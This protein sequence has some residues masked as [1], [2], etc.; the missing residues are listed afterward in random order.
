LRLGSQRKAK[1]QAAFSGLYQR[2]DR[3]DGLVQ[4]IAVEQL[5]ELPH[6][7]AEFAQGQPKWH[8]RAASQTHGGRHQAPRVVPKRGINHGFFTAGRAPSKLPRGWYD[9]CNKASRAEA[10]SLAI[11]QLE[12]L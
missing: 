8:T 10:G 6:L 2:R 11:I 12:G 9:G 4:L 3:V 1:P 7:C 5:S